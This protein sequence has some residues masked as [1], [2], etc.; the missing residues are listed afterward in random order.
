MDS[1]AIA[2][3]YLIE[4][5]KGGTKAERAVIM[6]NKRPDIDN[7]DKAVLDAI[8]GIAYQDDGC[9]CSN[10]SFKR[11]ARDNEQPGTHLRLYWVLS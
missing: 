1:V 11:Y 9:V 4:R 2:I 5:P 6:R 7:Y 3:E 8:S 10:L